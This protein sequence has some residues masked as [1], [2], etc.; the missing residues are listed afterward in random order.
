MPAEKALGTAEARKL[1]GYAA[2]GAGAQGG[3]PVSLQLR[4]QP[5]VKVKAAIDFQSA[6]TLYAG[7]A[8]NLSN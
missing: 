8:T 7:F 4:E 3:A 6:D 1:E 2:R 5:R